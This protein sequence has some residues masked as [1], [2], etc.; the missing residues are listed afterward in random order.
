MEAETAALLAARNLRPAPR[1]DANT[2]VL[3]TCVETIQGR[4]CAAEIARAGTTAVL[5]AA[6]PPLNDGGAGET[7]ALVA[8]TVQPVL[9]QRTPMLD[10][11]ELESQLMLVLDVDA[12]TLLEHTAAGWRPKDAK[13]LDRVV[14]WPRD[15]RGRLVVVGNGFEAFLPGRSCRGTL[16]PFDL[17][18]SDGRA[19]WPLGIEND[20]LADGRNFFTSPRVPPF[21]SV[22]PVSQPGESAWL[23]SAVDGGLRLVDSRFHVVGSFAGRGD[24]VVGLSGECVADQ[25]TVLVGQESP[26]GGGGS[27]RAF[28]LGNGHLVPLANPVSLPGEL[29]ALWPARAGSAALAVVHNL[30]LDRYEAF[31]VR[32]SCAR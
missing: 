32:L 1:A 15:V 6:R 24:D 7:R 16:D 28:E 12:V 30:G 26:D 20:G 14:S 29:L 9:A 3:V 8:L 19:P 10:V 2:H 11:V 31:L 22:A 21:Y 5:F 13:P 23:V 25:P 27:V 4:Q 17:A 18:C